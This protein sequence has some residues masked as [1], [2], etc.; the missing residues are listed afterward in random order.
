MPPTTKKLGPTQQIIIDAIGDRV[1]EREALLSQWQGAERAKMRKALT[2]LYTDGVIGAHDRENGERMYKINAKI[3]DGIAVIASAPE[4]DLSDI[5]PPPGD[6]PPG[7]HGHVFDTIFRPGYVDPPTLPPGYTAT[8]ADK[9]RDI[10]LSDITPEEDQA[11]HLIAGM[12]LGSLDRPPRRGLT[13]RVS[14]IVDP[15]PARG[16]ANVIS[17]DTFRAKLE[18][19]NHQRKPY[20]HSRARV[21]PP[22][23]PAVW[24]TIPGRS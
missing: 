9:L 13:M 12:I 4:F 1:V 22:A 7:S 2:R 3:A 21:S 14:G 10:D 16:I 19:A 24:V 17:G 15:N 23:R 6:P 8:A 5:G 11:A 20:R 18:R